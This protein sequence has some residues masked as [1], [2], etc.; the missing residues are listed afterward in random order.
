MT[1]NEIIKK[2]NLEEHIEGGWFKEVYENDLIYENKSILISIYFLLDKTT[3]QHT[4][5]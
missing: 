1:K 5:N 3:Y 2:L 4:T